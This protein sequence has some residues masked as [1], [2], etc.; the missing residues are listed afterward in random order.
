MDPGA[1][2]AQLC[3]RYGV[4]AGS[5]EALRLRGYLALLRKWNRRV[6]LTAST[7]W[8]AL[9]CQL[10]EALWAARFYPRDGRRHLDIG[11][12][13]GFPAVPLRILRPSMRLCMLESRSRKAAFLETVVAELGMAGTEVVCRRAEEYL[14][15]SAAGEWEA[16]SWKAVR[17]SSRALDALLASSAAGARFWMFHGP[18]LPLREP[19]RGAESLRLIRRERSPARPAWRLSIFEPQ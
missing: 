15:S 11:S 6:N 3:S 14:E 8:P 13:A 18:E 1:A 10:E 19:A 12:G 5:E 9:A 17:L 7:D 16:V 4:E 2:L